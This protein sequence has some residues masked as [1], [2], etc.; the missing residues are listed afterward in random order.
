MDNDILEFLVS[1]TIHYLS[2]RCDL[3]FSILHD[4]VALPIPH[5]ALPKVEISNL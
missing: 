4:L 2:I 5:M 3:P 1:F